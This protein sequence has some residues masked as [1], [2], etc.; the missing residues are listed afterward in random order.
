MPATDPTQTPEAF[1]AGHPLGRDAYERVREIVGRQGPFEVRTTRSQI[2]FRRRHG[3]AFLWL[4]GRYLRR[5]AADV[6]L[7]IALG[8]HDPSPRF[9]QVVHPSSRHWMH[10]LEVRAIR[11]LDAAVAGWLA[12]AAARAG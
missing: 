5:P 2:A 10:H 6:V 3:F 12:E 7:S 1:F 8:R 9:K 4:P 11:D